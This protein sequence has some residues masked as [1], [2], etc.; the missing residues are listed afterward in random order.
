MILMNDYPVL[1]PRDNLG[2]KGIFGK[3]C[4]I[5]G[6]WGHYPMIGAPAL[7]GRAALRSGCGLCTLAVP[8]PIVP[9]VLTLLPGA[10]AVALPV[11]AQQDLSAASCLQTLEPILAYTDT[12]LLGPGFGRGSAQ[13][14]IFWSLLDS[15]SKPLILDA[16]ALHLLA[17]RPAF[18]R[19]LKAPLLLTPHPGEF[20]V[21][22]QALDLTLDAVD[23][24]KRDQAALT[25]A[26]RLECVVILKGPYTR[27]SDGKQLWKSPHTEAALAIG[28]S[29]DV[30]SGICAG[31]AAQFTSSASTQCLDLF[32]VA[33][34]AVQIHALA[35]MAWSSRHGHA[36]LFPEELAD[37]IPLIMAQ[38]RGEL[39]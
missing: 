21:L 34:L 10:T 8:A 20:Q 1:P 39:I 31:F 22:A 32:Q 13:Q 38:L 29:G 25:L 28:G 35:A 16:D 5:G 4:V 33:C 18:A 24:Q 9:A 14:D 2:H 27:V 37:G 30:L 3:V 17:Q 15:F 11:N 7:A 12:L 23:E 26:E 36:G 6:S 19:T